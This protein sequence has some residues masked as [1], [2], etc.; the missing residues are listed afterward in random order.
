MILSDE[1]SCAPT[2]PEG[3]GFEATQQDSTLQPELD[4]QQQEDQ[5][6]APKMT[7]VKTGP[8]KPPAG[9]SAPAST[10]VALETQMAELADLKAKYE[11]LLAKVEADQRK[12]SPAVERPL[13][14]PSPKIAV[15]APPV[16]K[17]PAVIK[18][19]APEVVPV[20]PSPTCAP[21]ATRTPPPA[22][23]PTSVASKGRTSMDS[24][25]GASPTSV[26]SGAARPTSADG[27]STDSV[28]GA[29]PTSVASASGAARPTSADALKPGEEEL[30]EEFNMNHKD[31]KF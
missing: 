29:S 1:E 7:A 4:E 9:V 31:F 11:A 24:V 5:R 13:F 2:E 22:A 8:A 27:T 3:D 20:I 28:A 25:A 19:L 26:A 30:A 18:T 15:S 23:T 14:T 16:G 21:A 12:Q 10:P 17:A 6:G